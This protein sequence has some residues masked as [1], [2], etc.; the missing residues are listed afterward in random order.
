MVFGFVALIWPAL[1]MLMFINTVRTLMRD[2]G[3]GN[4][5]Q[6]VSPDSDDPSPT[7][8]RRPRKRKHGRPQQTTRLGVA[9]QH[10]L[11]PT[12]R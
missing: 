1:L 9:T 2:D 8:P 6:S 7:P 11:H 12:S 3:D 4:A 5:S 10:N